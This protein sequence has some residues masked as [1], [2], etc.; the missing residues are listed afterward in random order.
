MAQN[1]VIVESPAKAK[2]I[3]KYLGRRYL[4][5]ASIGHVRDLPKSQFAVDVDNGFTPKYITIR[6][7][8][9]V[10]KELRD[11]AKK[12]NKIFL[13]TDPDREGEAISWHLAQVLDV[14]PISPCRVTF[15]E[16]TKHTVQEAFKHPRPID[17][18][19]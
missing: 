3:G 15:N 2:T 11:A 5:K 9:A 13:A 17:Q 6:G 16:I 19:L 10:V 1:L 18:D 14:D 12:A 4:V 8:G 7:K